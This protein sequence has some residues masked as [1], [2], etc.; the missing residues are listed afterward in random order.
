MLDR[1]VDTIGRV[2][3]ILVITYAGYF[4]ISE[5]IRIIS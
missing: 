1:I 4:Y 5:L 3:I 2:G